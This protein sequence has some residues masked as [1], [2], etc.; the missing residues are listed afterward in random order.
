MRRHG[1]VHQGAGY[2]LAVRCAESLYRDEKT[3]RRTHLFLVLC[4]AVGETPGP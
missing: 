4:I 1:L 2:K 3:A